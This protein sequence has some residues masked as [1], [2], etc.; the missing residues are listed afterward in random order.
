LTNDQNRDIFSF[1]NTQ[2]LIT[3]KRRLSMRLQ[4]QFIQNAL[5]EAF[6]INT[7]NQEAPEF[8]IDSRTI[9]AGSIFVALKGARHDGHD[10]LHQAIEHG[11]IGILIDQKEKERLAA[12][13][14]QIEK[15]LFVVMVSNT[16][17][18]LMQLATAWRAQFTYP[19]IGITG[20]IGKTTTCR[21]LA[22]IAQKAGLSVLSPNA[23]YNSLIGTALTILRMRDT[24]Q[25]A[26]LEMGINKREE[27][28]QLAKM[29]RPSTAL[30]TCVGHSHMEG[31]G[32]IADVAAEKRDI[33]KYFQQ[34]NI[35]I[36]NGDQPLLAAVGYTHP[37]IKFGFKTTN[38]VQA[39]KISHESESTH[40][41]LKVYGKKYGMTVPSNHVSAVL[42]SL[43]AIAAAY[44]L[45]IPIETILQTVQEYV[46][47]EG[48]NEKRQI[49]K[50]KGIVINDC[51]N[52]SPES[53]KAALLSL[54]K[55]ETKGAKI[56]VLGDMLELGIGS[57]FW[58]RQVG[59]FLRK[60]PSVGQVI[61]VGSH[62]QETLKEVL[63][64]KPI[65][66]AVE[67]VPNWQEA[68]KKLSTVLSNDT[69]VLVKGSK[70]VGLNNI[71]EA[72]T[73]KPA[74]Q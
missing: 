20:S 32:S 5:P 61:L 53:V 26:V 33:F 18:A 28:A 74:Y 12:L 39:R 43:A 14:K 38:Q 56:A 55:Y 36:I 6:L 19:V 13:T 41:V 66:F 11:A 49:T 10:F 22:A 7:I 73:E 60:A 40:F 35:G 9:A 24:H 8:S 3:K 63:K 50:G 57:P 69:V 54:E 23:N 65:G 68:L 29:A 47:V 37:V 46:V 27:M 70:A 48:R 44:H 4:E 52:A 58:H 21:L 31:L 16:F 62:V 25:I 30:I 72:I 2:Y 1:I 17:S 51:Y 64:A 42:N 15:G 59:R 45:Q 67:L 71:V 34:S